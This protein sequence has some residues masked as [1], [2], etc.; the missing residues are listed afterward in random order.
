MSLKDKLRQV[1]IVMNKY[2]HIYNIQTNSEFL[3]ERYSSELIRNV[4]SIEKGL[5]LREVRP[6]FGVPKIK[7]AYRY[8]RS[9]IEHKVHSEEVCMFIGALRA[10]LEYHERNGLNN[11]NVEQVRK[12]YLDL[13]GREVTKKDVA[14]GYYTL[15]NSG[16]SKEKDLIITDVIKNRHSVREFDTSPIDDKLLL[17]AIDLARYCPSACNRQGFR[18][19][20]VSKEKMS[21]FDGWFD[22][23]GG[24][25]NEIQKMVL[26]TGKIS[27]YRVNEEFQYIVSASVFAGYLTMTLEAK[28]IGC[29]FV[30]RPVLHSRQWDKV[31]S[32]LNIDKDEQVIC[33]LGIGNLLEEY[34][35]PISHRINLEQIVSYH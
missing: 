23:I 16:Y 11:E 22:G 20:I 14:G 10:Y 18:V 27:A 4:H 6:F 28:N 34:K 17:E 21:V 1:Y 33:A 2:N 12:I 30:Q 26:V 15:K 25:A 24:F 35:V 13:L 19:H 32:E 5:S 9:L 7:E 8:A 29:C 3:N 31:S